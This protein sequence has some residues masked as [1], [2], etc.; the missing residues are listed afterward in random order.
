MDISLD[1]KFILIKNPT[2]KGTIIETHFSQFAGMCFFFWRFLSTKK[3]DLVQIT[4]LVL[5]PSEKV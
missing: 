4:A 2:K 1:Y 3:I 5:I